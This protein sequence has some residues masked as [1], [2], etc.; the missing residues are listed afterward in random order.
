MMILRYFEH[1]KLW[2]SATLDSRTFPTTEKPHNWIEVAPPDLG[3]ARRW[4][5]TPEMKLGW[6]TS[7]FVGGARKGNQIFSDPCLLGLGSDPFLLT[8][9]RP[10][11][12]DFGMLGFGTQRPDAKLSFRRKY[13]SMKRTKTSVFH[14]GQV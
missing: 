3:P 6:E 12:H 10:V 7:F 8:A 2:V 14:A 13:I 4:E 1:P 5:H 11:Q 9:W